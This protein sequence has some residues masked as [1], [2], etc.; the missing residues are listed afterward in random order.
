MCIQNEHKGV[1]PPWGYQ[2][3]GEAGLRI[4]VNDEL[5][6]E[7]IEACRVHDMTGAQV[8][9]AFMRSYIE[10]HSLAL[11]QLNLLGEKQEAD[12]P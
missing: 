10:Q 2:L 8:L 1:P 11:R 9:R 3:A 5:R 6:R 7:F 4:R 12:K